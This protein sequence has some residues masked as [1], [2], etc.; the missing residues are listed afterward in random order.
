[1]VEPVIGVLALQGAFAKQRMVIS[2]LNVPSR[3]VK[4]PE[5]LDGCDGLIIPGGESTTMTE[6][7]DFVGMRQPLEQFAHK[8]PVMG[9]C[10]GLILM[11]TQV[12][13]PRVKTL[14]I[15]NIDVVR[16][17]YGRQ[18]DS[19]VDTVDLL[20]DDRK[21]SIEGI[22]I[23]APRIR[24]VNREVEIIGTL[25]GEPV[26]VRQSRHL[27]C[28]FHPELSDSTAIHEYFV[29]MVKEPVLV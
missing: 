16:N 25:K 23:R 29:S 18:V 19:F 7:I 1:M 21:V 20:I 22:F 15:L 6:L 14:N 9:T 26:V 17:A 11:A 24:S 10:A 13:D 5:D 27:A 3:D 2:R 8:R 4:Y 12:S 28:T